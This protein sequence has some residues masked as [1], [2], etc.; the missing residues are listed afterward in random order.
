MNS[1]S[2]KVLLAVWRMLLREDGRNYNSYRFS[3][4]LGFILFLSFLANQE[5]ES[6]F[7]QFGGLV[8]RNVPGFCL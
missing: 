4:K 7:Q 6:D 1:G 8:T 3:Y 2:T 5:Q